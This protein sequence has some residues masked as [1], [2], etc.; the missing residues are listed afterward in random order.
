MHSAVRTTRSSVLM[1]ALWSLF[2]LASFAVTLGYQVRQKMVLVKRLESRNT[3][4]SIA[5][6]AI[7]AGI[8]EIRK[9]SE[10]ESFS[11]KD[12]WSSNPAFKD[13]AVASGTCS[14]VRD[15]AEPSAPEETAGYGLVDEES[16]VNVNTADMGVLA[17]LMQAALGVD[18]TQAQALAASLID[19]R[20]AD[21]ALVIPLGSA[22]DSYYRN[23]KFPY[24]AKDAL[25]EVP[26]EIRLVKGFD[27]NIFEKL[28]KYITIYGSGRV[29]VNTA[30]KVVL[31]SIGLPLKAVEKILEV[32]AG[33][34]GAAGTSDDSAFAGIGDVA[35]AVTKDGGFSPAEV[36]A[37]NNA[38]N[39][40]ATVV[41]TAFTVT[42]E[43]RSLTD[44]NAARVSCVVDLRGNILDYRRH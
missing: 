36:A 15:P 34:D 38:L 33:K 3:L 39:A 42:A 12:S 40:R 16:K 27:A 18:D 22:E 24:E 19:W 2:I 30:G 7:P 8:A 1:I 6:A 9:F 28:E 35:P 43:G 4:T 20:D 44:K 26:D 32:R 37:L 13:M 10:A 41:S 25:F 11:L 23:E 31:Y 29:N 17:A 14:F 5:E 21:S